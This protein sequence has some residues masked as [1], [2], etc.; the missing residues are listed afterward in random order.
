MLTTLQELM[1][2]PNLSEFILVG[3]TALSLQIGHRMSADID[4]FTTKAFDKP[5]LTNYL[6]AQHHFRLPSISDIAIRGFIDHVKVDLVS[7]ESGFLNPPL[8]MDDIKMAGLEDIAVMKLEAIANV[9][10]RLKDYVDIAFLS[11]YFSLEKMLA[12]FHKKFGLDQ[13]YAIRSLGTFSQ[14]QLSEN[15][16][17]INGKFEWSKI[18][19]RIK[20][21]IK[22]PTRTFNPI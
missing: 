15:I 11:E 17:L 7:Y 18:T 14:I 6:I 12:G 19:E 16:F 8:L 13:I 2:D 4:L 20:E 9:Q 10:N 1:R 5:V 22:N 21:M 3:G